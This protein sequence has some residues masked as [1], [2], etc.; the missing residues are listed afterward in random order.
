MH[1]LPP[2]LPPAHLHLHLQAARGRAS[3]AQPEAQRHAAAHPARRLHIPS[4]QKPE[5]RMP[6]LPP[7]LLPPAVLASLLASTLNW[8]PGPLPCWPRRAAPLLAPLLRASAVRVCATSSAASWCKTPTCA[9]PCKWVT[10]IM[11]LWRIAWQ[12]GY[13]KANRSA[14]LT[15]A[16]TS[17]AVACLN[18]PGLPCTE[19]HLYRPVYCTAG[20]PGTPLVHSGPQPGSPQ[21]QRRHCRGE[22]GQSALCRSA[23]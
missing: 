11:Q 16:L 23:G 2:A 15:S 13:L 18:R 12:P 14:F 20:D 5:V 21:L 19:L 8:P 7:L 1:A 6:P 10:P 9:P 3:E 22:L 17:H 4:Q